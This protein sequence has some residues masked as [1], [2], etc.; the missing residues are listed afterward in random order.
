MGRA[1]GAFRAGEGDHPSGQVTVSSPLSASGGREERREPKLSCRQC[2]G[3]ESAPGGRLPTSRED[4]DVGCPREPSQPGEHQ[5]LQKQ[6]EWRGGKGGRDQPGAEHTRCSERGRRL[7]ARPASLG[8]ARACRRP[9]PLARSG[10]PTKRENSPFLRG[11]DL[12][13]PKSGSAQQLEPGLEA[14]RC[15]GG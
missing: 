15:A 10:T 1:E 13:K 2:R 5:E 8:R 6:S 11:G 4:A 9:V 7:R 12:R 14:A 3:S